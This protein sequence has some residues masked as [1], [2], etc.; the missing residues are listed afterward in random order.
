[1]WTT[2]QTGRFRATFTSR[3]HEHDADAQLVIV[4]CPP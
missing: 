2:L 4:R 1:M 3:L